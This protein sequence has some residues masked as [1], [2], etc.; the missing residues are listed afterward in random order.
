MEQANCTYNK[1]GFFLMLSKVLGSMMPLFEAF[2]VPSFEIEIEMCRLL[3]K[4]S[5]L[6]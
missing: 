6:L 1:V 4:K 5:I 2:C 3:L